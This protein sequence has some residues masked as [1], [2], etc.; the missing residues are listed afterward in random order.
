MNPGASARPSALITGSSARSPQLTNGSDP[1]SLEPHIGRETRL[2]GPIHNRRVFYQRRWK[3]E[4]DDLIRQ[5]P[6][7][8]LLKVGKHDDAEIA[9]RDNG[10]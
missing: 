6:A 7:V 9:A 5:P 2:P 4:I 1:I 8:E 10:R 3:V